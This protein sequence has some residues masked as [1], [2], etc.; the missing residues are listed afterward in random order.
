MAAFDTGE[1]EAIRHGGT[2]W[3]P[4]ETTVLDKGFYTAWREASVLYRRHEPSGYIEF[5][6]LS[7]A[8]QRYRPAPLATASFELVDPPR[9]A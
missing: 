7:G 9:S 3:L 6:P 2:L 4:V 8:W 1:P 5:L